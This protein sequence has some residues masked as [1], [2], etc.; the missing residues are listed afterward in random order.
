MC[1]CTTTDHRPIHGYHSNVR[2]YLVGA[3]SIRYTL[4]WRLR[5]NELRQTTPHTFVY[6]CFFNAARAY[7][8]VPH[9]LLLHRLLQC[10]VMGPA[11]AVL[12]G[13]YSSAS[14]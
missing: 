1:A 2:S 12:S 4:W 8:L 7:D 13:M 5:G 6:A 11:F 14:R 3:R 10:G 9:T